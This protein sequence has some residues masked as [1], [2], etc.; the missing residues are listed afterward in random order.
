[1]SCWTHWGPEWGQLVRKT[2][3]NF[4]A[5]LVEHASVLW[6]RY[7]LSADGKTSYERL[8]GKRPRMRGLDPGEKVYWRSSTSAIHRTNKFESVW[9]DGVYLGHRTLS[10]ESIV[11]N[12]DGVFKSRTI[13][14][15]P[16]EDRWHYEL[17]HSLGGIP[18]KVN[19]QPEEG[20]QVMQGSVPPAPSAYPAVPPEPPQVVF[21]EEASRKSM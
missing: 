21:R 17:L 12:K 8:R 20:D 5:W 18:W 10:G 14:R 9:T 16:T 15:V 13:R 19:P 7:A 3:A 6:N 4:M 2:S 1:M 11:G